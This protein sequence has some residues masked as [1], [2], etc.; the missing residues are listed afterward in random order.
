MTDPFGECSNDSKIDREIEERAA[1][2]AEYEA[3]IDK[4]IAALQAEVERLRRF[5]GLG[6]EEEK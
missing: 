1:I 2:R 6:K 4:C 5:L 3:T